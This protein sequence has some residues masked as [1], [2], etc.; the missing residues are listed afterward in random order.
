MLTGIHFLLTYHCTSECDHCFLYC[1]PRSTGTF[2]INQIN[3][4]LNEAAKIDTVEWVYFEGGEPFLYYPVLLA[5]VKAARRLGY[6]IGIVTNA[7]FACSEEDALLWLKPLAEQGIADFSVSDDLFHFSGPAEMSPA[8]IA[9]RAAVK[10][11][12]NTDTICIEHPATVAAAGGDIKQGKPVAGGSVMLRGRAAEKLA[13][14][15]PG[16]PSERFRECPYE[17]LSRPGRVHLDAYGHVQICQGLSIG[18]MWDEPLSGIIAGYDA[19][20]HPLCGPLAEGGPDLLAKIYGVPHEEKYG[21][22]CHYCYCLRT[23]LIERFPRYLA[24]RQVYGLDGDI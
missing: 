16:Q 20:T 1:S 8:G 10:L 17:N 13:R 2:T 23:A 24:P 7:Y 11:G 19:G 21:D 18:N 4:A 6:K 22:A 12:M 9:Y 3:A 5:G 14:E 15:M